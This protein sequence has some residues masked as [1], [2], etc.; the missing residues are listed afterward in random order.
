[1]KSYNSPYSLNDD[2]TP[3]QFEEFR[4]SGEINHRT[5]YT[6][7]LALRLERRERKAEAQRLGL[8]GDDPPE[9]SIEDEVVLDH[10]WASFAAEKTEEI[11]HAFAA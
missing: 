7:F 1:M 3:E 4:L 10:V 11:E 6:D 2:L 8:T 5:T 9:L